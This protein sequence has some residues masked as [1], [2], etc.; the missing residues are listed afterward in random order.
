MKIFLNEKELL[1]YDNNKY[2]ENTILIL[3]LNLKSK[4]IK[5]L[6]NI[7]S[8]YSF[9]HPIIDNSYLYLYK[10]SKIK[11]ESVYKFQTNKDLLK[12]VKFSIKNYNNENF[13]KNNIKINEKSIEYLKKYTFFDFDVGNGKKGQKEIS[14]IFTLTPLDN[15]NIEA[16]IIDN[17]T[18]IGENEKAGYKKTVGSFHTHPY[19][20][21]VRHNVCI[22]YPSADDYF[23]VMYIYASGH[24]AFHIV[25]TVEGIYIITIKP[26]FMKKDQKDIL[27]NF[28]K[29]KNDI[30]DKYG[31]DY[32]ICNPKENNT[33]KWNKKIPEYI[34]KIN[35]LPYFKVKFL[36][37]DEC[38][39]PI[40]IKYKKINDNCIICDR[41]YRFKKLINSDISD[42]SKVS[43]A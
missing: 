34:K 39:N 4:K 1:E 17:N 8:E 35:N 25:S 5:E 13:C 32:P 7:A 38:H 16:S 14:G 19:N 42:I 2:D 22:A 28:E 29:Y 20:A 37:W 6:I 21:Y 41:Q 33:K 10:K 26:S 9:D 27:H 30:E 43:D 31:V 15:E 18:K 3:K 11:N 12:S 40:E 24:Y 23:T 36:K